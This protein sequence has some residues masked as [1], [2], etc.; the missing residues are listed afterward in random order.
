MATRRVAHSPYMGLGSHEFPDSGDEVRSGRRLFLQEIAAHIPTVLQTLHDGP[1]KQFRPY[2]TLAFGPLILGRITDH[3]KLP[4]STAQERHLTKWLAE[5]RQ[6]EAMYPALPALRTWAADWYLDVPWVRNRAVST[7]YT[8]WLQEASGLAIQIDWGL[9]VG[10]VYEVLITPEE[11]AFTPTLPIWEPGHQSRA[12]A[13]ASIEA[14]F[15]EQLRTY[16]D[17][18]ETLSKERGLRKK[19]GKRQPEH[20]EWFARYQCGGEEAGDIAKGLQDEE[21]ARLTA[22]RKA[23][24]ATVEASLEAVGRAKATADA[25]SKAVE[26][27]HAERGE[28]AKAT[29]DAPANLT[30]RDALQEAVRTAHQVYQAAVVE[31]NLRANAFRA[32]QKAE[33]AAQ[34]KGTESSTVRSAINAVSTLLGVPK[35]KARLGRPE[36]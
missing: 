6:G 14:A 2:V 11:L 18:V 29:T 35:R 13:Q 7:M 15:N 5:Q 22:E 36:N 20:F 23:A 17:G 30:D 27:A 31:H 19:R 34:K 3:D 33:S 25:S 28:A 1:Y 10:D 9:D 12:E 4:R 8:W 16:L 24:K 26:R 32:A 21:R